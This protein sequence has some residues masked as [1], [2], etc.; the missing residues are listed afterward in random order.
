MDLMKLQTAKFFAKIELYV[1][2]LFFV[3]GS[4]IKAPIAILNCLFAR[5]LCFDDPSCSAILEIIPRVCGPELG[6]SF[7]IQFLI[8]KFKIITKYIFILFSLF[9]IKKIK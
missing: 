8:S 5:Q 4:D 1:V 6:E 3:T 7:S 9:N 2:S